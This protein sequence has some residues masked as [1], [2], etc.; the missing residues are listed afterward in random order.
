[1]TGN[2]VRVRVTDCVSVTG[3]VDLNIY[4]DPTDMSKI[5]YLLEIRGAPDLSFVVCPLDSQ[6]WKGRNLQWPGLR[7]C[8]MNVKSIELVDAQRLNCLENIV[9]KDLIP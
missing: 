4:F 2:Q 1:M 9:W 3:E 8:S 7:V 6:I 5:L